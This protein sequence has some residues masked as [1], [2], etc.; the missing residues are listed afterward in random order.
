MHFE[1]LWEKA[2]TTTDPESSSFE[3]LNE[4]E[5]KMSLLKN[6]VSSGLSGDDRSQAIGVSLGS[7]LKNLA[8]IS[9]KENINVF[10]ALNQSLIGE[11]IKD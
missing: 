10:A 11:S 7:I 6:I 2:E 4:L 3:I 5:I 9:M 1:E 8:H